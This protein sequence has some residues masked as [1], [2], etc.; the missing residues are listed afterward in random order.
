MLKATERVRCADRLC[1]GCGGWFEKAKRQ[2]VEL[3]GNEVDLLELQGE[4]I[5][6]SGFDAGDVGRWYGGFPLLPSAICNLPFSC[7]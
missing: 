2:P 3:V 6:N 5:C 1:F 4:E 7:P